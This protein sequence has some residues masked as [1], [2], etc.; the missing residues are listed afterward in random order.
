MKPTCNYCGRDAELATG[1]Q[2]YR[3]R[4][5]LAALK[6]WRC[7]RCDAYVGCHAAGDFTTDAQGRKIYSD[8]T[9]PKGTL[10]DAKLRAAR[11]VA[12]V[13]FDALWRDA[14]DPKAARLEAYAWL[15]L[16]LH[17]PVDECHI[18]MFDAEQCSRVVRACKGADVTPP[19]TT[20]RAIA[21]ETDKPCA[22]DALL[23][24]DTETTGL[25]I[26]SSP[27]ED[28]AQPHLVQL[29]A[30]LVDLDTRKTI[31]SFDVIVRPE[32]WTIPDEV[33]AIHGITTEKAMDLGVS[34][35]M[36]VGMLLEFWRDH[37]PRL[38]VAH[39]EG[40]DSRIIRIALMRHEDEALA[41]KWK[42][43]PAV[44]T[45]LLSQSIV[46][47]PP[48]EKMLAAGRSHSK[49]PSLGEAYKHF[50]GQELP[51]A[52]TA[53]GDVLGVMAVYFGIVDHKARA[54]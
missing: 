38:R 3:S 11:R 25:P 26:W 50:T 40:F 23:F 1:A 43:G 53:M 44:C 29:A 20:E 42:D 49:K 12:H 54:V 34:E 10:A 24:F 19:P 4:A 27:S 36:A 9:L 18:G 13:A 31:S 39:N 45:A 35:S 17:I 6:F 46:K 2:I 37:D 5:D 28:P 51:N 21:M 33:A 7:I 52:H 41:N 8:G 30:C 32:G 22:N 16:Q 14:A 47:A 15:A 48:T